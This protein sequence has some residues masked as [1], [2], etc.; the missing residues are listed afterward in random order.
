MSGATKSI[1]CVVTCL[2]D[3]RTFVFRPGRI[4]KAK[5]TPN[6]FNYNAMLFFDIFFTNTRPELPVVLALKQQKCSLQR[7]QKDILWDEDTIWKL[8]WCNFGKMTDNTVIEA[9]IRKTKKA[10]FHLQ[11]FVSQCFNNKVLVSDGIF[12]S[13]LW[14]I[15]Y[16]FHSMK[17]MLY[18]CFAVQT[19]CNCTSI[20][21]FVRCVC[22]HNM[23]NM[24]SIYSYSY[25]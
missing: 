5:R 12:L 10:F 13:N 1:Y 14:K 8:C 24:D 20:D 2:S 15:I 19:I 3:P 25:I 16:I 9:K 4:Q 21:P 11:H 17:S 6:L 23:H 22:I 7:P 18:T